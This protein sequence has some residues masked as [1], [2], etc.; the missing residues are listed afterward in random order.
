MTSFN[1][2]S[3]CTHCKLHN[4]SMPNK[5]L[6]KLKKKREKKYELHSLN[7]SWLKALTN[8]TAATNAVTD[9]AVNKIINIYHRLDDS[10]YS[11]QYLLPSSSGKKKK[12]LELLISAHIIHSFHQFFP[13]QSN[14]LLFCDKI[15]WERIDGC[16]ISKSNH[17]N[18]MKTTWRMKR[19]WNWCAFTCVIITFPTQYLFVATHDNRFSYCY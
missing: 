2:W 4:W 13:F 11:K 6:S 3:V 16:K 8:Y 17:T 19:I 9:A 15:I 12:L 10:Q 7:A 1:W 5:G 18:K 14:F